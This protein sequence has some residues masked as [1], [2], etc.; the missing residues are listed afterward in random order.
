MS[1]IGQ[2]LV[3]PG[4][5]AKEA[6]P[7][8]FQ[9]LQDQSC[10]CTAL[11]LSHQSGSSLR[12]A[13]GLFISVF[14]TLSQSLA[15]NEHILNVCWMHECQQPSARVNLP[16]K[17]VTFPCV[18]HLWVLCVCTKPKSDGIIWCSDCCFYISVLRRET[19]LGKMYWKGSSLCSLVTNPKMQPL[20][21]PR[22]NWN[23]PGGPGSTLLRT[24][25]RV[26]S[27]GLT[28]PTEKHGQACLSKRGR[29]V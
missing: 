15:Q 28:Q 22:W 19:K 9:V 24:W 8:F 17:G 7:K 29:N 6:E 1:I 13:Q 21:G 14:P 25:H 3:P 5:L 11:H 20:P 18:I 12:T 4:E 23:L 16:G 26:G 27:P 2:M 10:H